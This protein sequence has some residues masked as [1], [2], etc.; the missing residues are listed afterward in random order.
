MN[1]IQPA[2]GAPMNYYYFLRRMSFLTSA[3]LLSTTCAHAHH[4]MGGKTPSTF[5]DGL[6]SGLGHPLIGPDHLAFLLAIGIA[7]GVGGLNLALALVFVITSGI[8]VALHV[9]AVDLPGA[10]IIVAASVLLAGMLLVRGRPLP[11]IVWAG[12]FTIAG[13]FHG[14]AFGESIVGAESSPLAAYLSGLV[15]I[16][17]TLM[18]LVALF[19]RWIGARVSE[20]APRLVGAGITGVGLTVLIGQLLPTA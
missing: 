16:Q 1:K 12:F 3:V 6:L 4:L 18:T 7:I 2:A 19:S 11:T 15:V 10:E 9:D 17:S 14:Y 5:A 8:G 20:F 13:L